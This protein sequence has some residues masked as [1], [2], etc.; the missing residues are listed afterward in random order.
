M[1]HT[2]MEVATKG[3]LVSVLEQN[4]LEEFMQLAQLS[5]KNFEAERKA[6]VVVYDSQ[7]IFGGDL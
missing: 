2:T 3:P 1:Q 4:S 6:N 7:L 5:S